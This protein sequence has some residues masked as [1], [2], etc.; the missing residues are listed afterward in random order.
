[1]KWRNVTGEMIHS[2]TISSLQLATEMLFPK[3]PKSI[4]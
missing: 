2:R 4:P 1:M 3:F